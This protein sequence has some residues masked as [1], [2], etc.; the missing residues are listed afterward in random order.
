MRT[1]PETLKDTPHVYQTERRTRHAERPG[2]PIA[3]LQISPTQKVLWHYHTPVQ[4][5]LDVLEGA[6]RVSL[7]DPK[8]DVVLAPGETYT[9]RHAGRIWSRTQVTQ[10]ISAGGVK[11]TSSRLMSAA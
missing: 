10:R 9:I 2:F 6:Q 5:T 4:D 7:R 3:E 11:S 8:E 1:F